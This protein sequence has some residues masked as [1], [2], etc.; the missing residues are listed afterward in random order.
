MSSSLSLGR[1]P[2]GTEHTSSRQ[3]VEKELASLVEATRIDAPIHVVPY[4]PRWVAKFEDERVVLEALLAPWRLGPIEH[5]GSTA[6]PGL[7]AKPVID[8]MVGVPSLSG[9][10]PTKAAL[11]GVG[12][13][14]AEYKTDVMHWFC[15]FPR[16]RLQTRKK[17]VS[18][19]SGAAVPDLPLPSCCPP[20]PCTT[21]TE[22][23]PFPCKPVA[24]TTAAPCPCR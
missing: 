18:P 17:K 14:Y 2:E 16:D 13:Q 23:Y 5:V 22:S 6:V 8:V 19:R 20:P 21:A 24:S 9:S 1:K 12:Y 7:C 3:A 11:R 4:D 15:N 10:E